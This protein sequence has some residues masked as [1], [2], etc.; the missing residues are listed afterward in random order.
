MLQLR[1][2]S[3][4]H[5]KISNPSEYN[6]LWG[7]AG[8]LD[9]TSP[10]SLAEVSALRP[11]Q[12]SPDPLLFSAGNKDHRSH[13]APSR[14]HGPS[15]QLSI[16]STTDHRK[17]QFQR[18]QQRSRARQGI[19]YLKIE[20]LESSLGIDWTM[21][22]VYECLFCGVLS[23]DILIF[24]GTSSTGKWLQLWTKGKVL[25]I[26]PE[27]ARNGWVWIGVKWTR[28]SERWDQAQ[29]EKYNQGTVPAYRW[30]DIADSRFI[31]IGSWWWQYIMTVVAE[32]NGSDWLYDWNLW[33]KDT[34]L[35][36]ETS[37]KLFG[38]VLS[39]GPASPQSMW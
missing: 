20:F 22:S 18:R 17:D 9:R 4:F 33:W 28:Y 19:D 15:D 2:S 24:W 7:E 1:M 25:K 11:P 14:R 6:I 8:P 12:S 36:A 37:A 34:L 13:S 21:W 30:R 23:G 26:D 3:L 31:R 10:N 27:Q 35:T 32:Q 5:R 29:K 16:P 38:D 39:N